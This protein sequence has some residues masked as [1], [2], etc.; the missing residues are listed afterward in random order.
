VI[1][2]VVAAAA[3]ETMARSGIFPPALVPTL[4][5][6]GSTLLA[7]L[8]DGTMLAH[9]FYTLYR[10]L[11]GMA[12]AIAV[13]LPLGILM[14]RFKPIEN[15]FLPLASALMPIP[16]LAWVPVFILWFGI[17]NTV[18]ILIVFYAATFPL[19]LNAW[20]GVRAVNPLWLRAAGAMGANERALFWKV[21]IP[22]AFP[23]IITGVRQAFLRA[24]IAVVGAEMIAA[25]DWGLGWVIYD[26]KEFLNADVML[27]SLAVIGAIG[28][29]FERLA[30]GSIERAT[31]MR[32]G[33]V[34][35]AKG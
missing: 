23:F 13:G 35:T 17:G 19:L 3:Y 30:F 14:G 8:L 15:F 21:I 10:V 1:T 4:P 6:V 24:W 28:F 26:A 34:R 16:S 2:L 31:V 33:M 22:G 12:L 25:S 20:S 11:L 5:K 32:W 18:S 29:L 9:A 7:L 27:A